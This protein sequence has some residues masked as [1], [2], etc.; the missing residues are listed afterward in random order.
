MDKGGPHK[1]K[2]EKSSPDRGARCTTTQK[3]L[4]ATNGN[5]NSK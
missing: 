5:C 4:D 2:K 3:R 1:R